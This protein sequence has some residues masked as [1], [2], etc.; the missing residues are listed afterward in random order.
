MISPEL[1]DKLIQAAREVRQNAYAPYSRY[2]VGAAILLADGRIYTGVNV[3]NAS[4]GLS[5][6]AER[7]A[8]FKMVSEGRG[9]IVAVAVCTAN[10]GS[11][12]GAC[13]QVLAEFADDVPVWLVDDKGNGRD[14]TLY[15]LLPDHFG[16]EHLETGR[17]GD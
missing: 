7:T 3:E 5:I 4:Y 9:E 11:P 14:T 6:C 1:R 13:R 12:C 10:A 16:P 17:T 15:T 8:V 2:R